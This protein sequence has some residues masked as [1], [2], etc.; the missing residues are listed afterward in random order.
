MKRSAKERQELIE[1]WRQ[2]GKSKK[3]FCYENRLNYMTFISWGGKRSS[4]GIGGFTPLNIL[5]EASRN[6]AGLP[7]AEVTYSNGC[8]ITLHKSVTV[9]Y[10]RN[11]IK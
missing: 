11:L 8:N 2:S 9:Q 1:Q 3:A 5:P 6:T 4:A 10:L 7:F